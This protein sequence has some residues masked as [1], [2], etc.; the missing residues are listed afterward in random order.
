MKKVQKIG[1]DLGTTYSTISYVNDAGVVE[2]IPN[3]EGDL[4]TPSIV[5]YASGKPIVGKAAMPDLVLSPEFVVTHG[6]RQMSEATSDGKPISI[7]M[8]PSGAE[9]TPV[10]S[11]A[12]LISYM[13]QS[14]E[15]Y[16]GYKVDR[17]VI[18][19]PAYFEEFPRMNTITAAVI[20][21]FKKE[22]VILLDEPVSAAIYYGLE[23]ARNERIAVVDFGGGT[24]DISIIE[25]DGTN[26]KA[27]ITDGDSELGGSNYDE[28]ILNDM[29]SAG[30]KAGFQIS[31]DLATFYQNREKAQEG[32]EMLS[33]RETVT[34]VPTANGQRTSLSYTRKM[35][36]KSTRDFDDRFLKCCQRVK[37]EAEKRRL[38]IDRVVLVGGSVRLPH[39]PS[40]VKSV[41]G[42]EPSR[43]TDP[44]FVVAKGAGIWVQNKFGD[45]DSNIIVGS[46]HYLASEIK[47][48]TVAAHAICVA[49]HKDK[50]DP[51]EYN[52]PIVPANSPL[53]H[54]FTERFSPLLPSQTSVDVKL[55]QGKENE[56]SSNSTLLRTVTVPIKA[57]D[58]DGNR[59]CVN[60][61]Y[62]EQG[63]L[64]ITIVDDLLGK[65]ISDSFIHKAGL[66][67][68]EIKQKTSHLKEMSE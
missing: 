18:T 32:K 50:N 61:R 43:D 19:V 5:S 67:D 55:I 44:D 3:M 41:F 68:A 23:K 29:D 64:E 58:K 62:T 35:L 60:G 24:L 56:L 34:L 66:S 28:A 63:I 16:L 39:V 13:K 51:N 45:P 49:A 9:I 40:M 8:D 33:R 1:M 6:K 25:I 46:K 22:N 17:L 37:A 54:D 20:A 11:S 38:Q 10:D 2:L 59:I 42:I 65:P 4:K 12:A 47:V 57:S 15:A 27:V 26:I 31:A 30:K 52:C 36:Q 21:G 48:Q 53:P 14:A 7:I